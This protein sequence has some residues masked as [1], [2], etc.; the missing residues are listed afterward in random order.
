MTENKSWISTCNVN[1]LRCRKCNFPFHSS[2]YITLS[3]LFLYMSFSLSPSFKFLSQSLKLSTYISFFLTSILLFLVE[4]I[5]QLPFSVFRFYNSFFLI[6]ILVFLVEFL[7]QILI[8]IFTLVK[9]HLSLVY[10]SLSRWVYL[11][12]SFLTL[13]F[14]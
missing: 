6:S 9:L 5:F 2:V 3:S 11:S 7:F 14:L 8:S 4:S 10:T 12:T 13:S 1:N